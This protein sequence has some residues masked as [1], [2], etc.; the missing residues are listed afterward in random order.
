ML[1]TDR[2][3][4]KRFT[5]FQFKLMK[6]HY[7]TYLVIGLFNSKYSEQCKADMKMDNSEM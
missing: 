2:I 7:I 5:G 3:I 4:T 6:T 1:G